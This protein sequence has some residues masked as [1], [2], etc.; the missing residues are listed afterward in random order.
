VVRDFTIGDISP[1]SRRLATGDS[2]AFDWTG[3]C[4]GTTVPYIRIWMA[5]DE[6]H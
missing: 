3:S 4:T 6:N 2:V 5:A 1:V